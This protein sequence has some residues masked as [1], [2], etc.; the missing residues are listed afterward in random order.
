MFPARLRSAALA[1]LVGAL[2]LP[3]TAGEPPVEPEI[4]LVPKDYPT[5][6]A[7]VNAAL[8]GD[9]IRIAKGVYAESVT[10]TGKSGLL[11]RGKGAIVNPGG[12][13]LAFTL[14]GCSDIVIEGLHFRNTW[15]WPLIDCIGGSNLVFRRLRFSQGNYAIYTGNV[16]GVVIERIVAQDLSGGLLFFENTSD[17]LVSRVRMLRCYQVL[18]GSTGS[19][20]RV[21]RLT[22]SK[23]ADRGIDLGWSGP[24]HDVTLERV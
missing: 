21:E 18:N 11:I 2:S 6:Q 10:L 23:V 12:G 15:D 3:A 24:V 7:A 8:P 5:I 22:A 13:A 9:E 16:D 17:V 19:D 4:R 14:T 20:L 1:L